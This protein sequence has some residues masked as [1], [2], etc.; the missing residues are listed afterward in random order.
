MRIHTPQSIVIGSPLCGMDLR[1][2]L[3]V[4]LKMRYMLHVNC[5][6]ESVK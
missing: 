2:F 3:V 5:K 1:G 4:H 6:K